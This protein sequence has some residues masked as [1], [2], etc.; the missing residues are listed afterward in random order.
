M[1]NGFRWKREEICGFLDQPLRSRVNKT[2][3][4]FKLCFDAAAAQPTPDAVDDLRDA[5][6]QLMRAASRVL[7]ELSRLHAPPR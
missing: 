7:L 2:V 3:A 6:D 4:E 5:T 1:A